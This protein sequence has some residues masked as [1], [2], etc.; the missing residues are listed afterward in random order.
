M[1]RMESLFRYTAPP[2]MCGYLPTQRWSLE[3][4][5]VANLSAW[6]YEERLTQGWRRFGAM[7]FHPMCPACRACQSLRVDV[8]N[9]QPSRSQ[10]RA[11]NANQEQIKRRVGLPSV[12]R[13]KLD[14]YDRFHDF[15]TDL[16][17]WPEHAAKDPDSYRESFV[18]NPAF[19]EEWCY[20][21]D[22]RLV[23]VG[24]ADRLAASMSAIYFFY[25]PDVRDRSLGTFNVLCLLEECRMR[26]LPHLYLG[27]YVEGCR[28]L[29]YKAAY[30]PN[31]VLH[32][33]GEWRDFLR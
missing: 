11:W 2:S 29:E 21:L 10:R 32:P 5:M 24:Y 9:F 23:G 14:L 16:K 25:D 33:D 1:K 26:K 18:H 6:E 20:Y 15:Q 17:G 22:G 30:K 19:T 13:A 8:R 27:Y 12:S 28:S 7:L 31:Q 3:Y 4:E